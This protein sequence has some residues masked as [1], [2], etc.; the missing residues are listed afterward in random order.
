MTHSS[1]NH[2]VSSP[3]L[4]FLAQQQDNPVP[5]LPE[6]DQFWLPRAGSD[7]A[8]SSDA[9]FHYIMWVSAISVILILAAM[10]YICIKY[11]AG[12][13][14]ENKAAESQLDHSNVLEAIWSGL[15]IF[16]LVTFFVWGFKDFVIFKSAP[17]DAVE[18]YATGQK[19]KWTFKY[20]NGHVDGELH[21]PQGKNTRVIIKSVDVL[22]SLFLP[23]FR[24]KMD[25]VPGRYTDLW[26]K[27]DYAGTFPIFCA[28]YCGKQHSDMLTQVVVHD[29]NGYEE[30]LEKKE[31][32]IEDMPPVQLGEAM[33][34]Q[35]GCAACHTLD[36]SPNTGPT[37]KGLFGRTEALV[38]GRQ[39]VVDENYIRDSIL[40]PQKDIVQGY[41]PQMPSFQ[42]QL[43]DKKIDGLIAYIK[44]LK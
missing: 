24:V 36:G 3:L 23:E 39:Q 8:K 11:Q 28:E 10:V 25:A 4:S 40:M 9:L 41:P 29:G 42:G 6:S 1:T 21:V 2:A 7:F 37:F 31:K 13:R 27:P 30:W 5:K 33:Y 17:R 35:F 43:S 38:G 16:F 44:T 26:F 12:K 18:I 32:E 15:P 20:P 34:K 14:S 19:W 22:H